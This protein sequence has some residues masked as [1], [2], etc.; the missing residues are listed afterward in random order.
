MACWNRSLRASVPLSKR[1]APAD[2]GARSSARVRN[3]ALQMPAPIG[4]RGLVDPA[5]LAGDFAPVVEANGGRGACPCNEACEFRREAA[6]NKAGNAAD[7]RRV[8]PC[9]PPRPA[10]APSG[11]KRADKIVPARQPLRFE[12]MI[13]SQRRIV[14]DR[15]AGREEALLEI[16]V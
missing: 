1:A 3:C 4:P 8:D 9:R 5:E 7:P 13:L 11:A 10:F 14:E 2:H 16:D 15:A 6:E 12:V